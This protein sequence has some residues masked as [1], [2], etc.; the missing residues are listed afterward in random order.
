L[1][2]DNIEV[3]SIWKIAGGAFF[4]IAFRPCCAINDIIQSLHVLLVRSEIL[5]KKIV[6]TE[7]IGIFIDPAI[8]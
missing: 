2:Y 5:L 4:E 8:R 7:S 1:K 3:T 6:R